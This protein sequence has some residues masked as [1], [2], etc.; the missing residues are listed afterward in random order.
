MIRFSAFF[1]YPSIEIFLDKGKPGPRLDKYSLRT[2]VND[3]SLLS[4]S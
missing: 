3:S 2:V 4:S 1:A